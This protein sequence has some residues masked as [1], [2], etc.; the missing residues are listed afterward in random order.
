VPT[1]PVSNRCGVPS[2]VLVACCVSQGECCLDD[3]SDAGA[4]T[5]KSYV[6]FRLDRIEQKLDLIASRLTQLEANM[7]AA[8]EVLRQEVERSNT[9]AASAVT[10]IQGLADRIEASKGDPIALQA[11]ADDLRGGTDAL[12][13]AVEA[14]TPSEPEE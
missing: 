3:V 4:R 14:N 9:V 2:A 10:L 13:D 6:L 1:W 11:I 7:T 5:M 12:A 8:M